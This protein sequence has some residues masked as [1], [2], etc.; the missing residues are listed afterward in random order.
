M[1]NSNES[2][3]FIE[4]II[5]LILSNAITNIALNQTEFIKKRIFL[6]SAECIKPN[7]K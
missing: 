1:E 7:P 2:E 5:D 6:S 4:E 3:L